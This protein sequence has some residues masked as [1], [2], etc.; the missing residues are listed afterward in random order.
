MPGTSQK[1][2]SAGYSSSRPAQKRA[3]LASRPRV[4]CSSSAWKR[5]RSGASCS[6]SA[7]RAGCSGSSAACAPGCWRRQVKTSPATSSRPWPRRPGRPSGLGKLG[8]LAHQMRPAQLL[9]QDV[10]PVIS[11][12]AITGH[13]PVEVL[14]QQP[15]GGLLGAPR[16]DAVAHDQRGRGRP[17]PARVAVGQPRRLVGMDRLGRPDRLVQLTPRVVQDAADTPDHAVDRADADTQPIGVCQQLGDL[18]ARQAPRARQHRDVR[19][20]SGPERTR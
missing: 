9:L 2:H 8:Q 15:L 14:A 16:V 1:V 4:P 20:Q 19:V 10:K 7:T 5:S 13:E 17:Q 18:L 6:R 12:V 11:G 3:V